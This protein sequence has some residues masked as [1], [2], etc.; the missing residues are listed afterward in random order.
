MGYTVT[1]METT[2][3][4]EEETKKWNIYTCVPT[5]IRKLLKIAGEPYWKEEEPS[6]NGSMRIIAGKWILEEK[7][8]RF[9]TKSIPKEITE[10]QRAV[11]RERMLQLHEKRKQNAVRGN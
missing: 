11:L 10:E 5:H 6:T 4:F 8:V 2:C 3:T 7:Q 9:V 1:E